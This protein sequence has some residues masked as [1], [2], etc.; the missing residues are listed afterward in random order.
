MS[1]PLVLYP[2]GNMFS[3]PKP[4][5]KICL[6]YYGSPEKQEWCDICIAGYRYRDGEGVTETDKELAHTSCLQRL[7]S[8]EVCMGS[9]QAGEPGKTTV[10]FQPNDARLQVHKETLFQFTPEGRIK[11]KPQIKGPGAQ[12]MLSFSEEGQS[13]SSMQ[14]FN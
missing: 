2:K 5:Q 1:S 9:W 7:P 3:Y 12:R 8:P 11:P 6:L 10:W 4:C 14:V 13:L